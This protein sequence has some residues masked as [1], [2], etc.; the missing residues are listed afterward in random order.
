MKKLILSAFALTCAASV[1]AQGTVV[2]NNRVAGTTISYV[3]APLASDTQRAQ[4][5]NDATGFPTGSTDWTGWTRIGASGTGGQYG[6]ATTYAVLLSAPGLNQ[7]M[8]S[9]APA[10][11]LT[12]FRTGAAAGNVTG[13]TATL[14]N[15]PADAPSATLAMAAWDNS[16]GQYGTYALALQAWQEGALA[17]GF[18]SPFN[19]TAIGGSLN[20]A[21]TLN[22]LRSFNLTIV[23]EPS[24]FAL[25][26]LGAAAL[27]IFRRRK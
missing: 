10:T 4:S 2:F 3:Y 7:P 5:G 18:S 23:P 1:F 12:T 9:L 25:V 21:P 20:P 24:S 6:A 8:S 27:L 16:S 13:T 14:G 15:V 11:P 22:D 17:M 26:G 19:V